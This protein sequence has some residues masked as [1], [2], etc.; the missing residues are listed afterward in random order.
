MLIPFALEN[1]QIPPYLS[2]TDSLPLAFT[3]IYDGATPVAAEAEEDSKEQAQ[4]E[5]PVKNLRWALQH[6]RVVDLDIKGGIIATDGSFY[7]SFV[8]LLTKAIKSETNT[9]RTPIVLS[10]W[11]SS[12][13]NLMLT[14]IVQLTYYPLQSTPSRRS[15][16]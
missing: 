13:L 8:N 7:D 3:T 5:S 11:H 9:T 2:Q 12:S 1:T 10:R 16:R 15:L 6:G 4:L 14:R